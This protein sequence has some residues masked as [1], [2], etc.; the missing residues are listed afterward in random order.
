MSSV[1]DD[2][3][4]CPHMMQCT[5]SPYFFELGLFMA[6]DQIFLSFF[7]CYCFVAFLLYRSLAVATNILFVDKSIIVFLSPM[8]F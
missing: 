2:S 5:A 3:V 4:V 6:V 7:F 1:A 8:L